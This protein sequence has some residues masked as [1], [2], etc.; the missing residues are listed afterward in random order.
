MWSFRI[1]IDLQE[2]R[3]RIVGRESIYFLLYYFRGIIPFDY[4][5]WMTALSQH[6][7]WCVPSSPPSPCRSLCWLY[8]ENG[9]DIRIM[10]CVEGPKKCRCWKAKI[11]DLVLGPQPPLVVWILCFITPMDRAHVQLSK[12]VL[13]FKNGQ[14]IKVLKLFE[15]YAVK[16]GKS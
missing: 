8:G 15:V 13:I 12:S 2:A 3:K 1:E 10:M 5:Y 9:V 11:D 16:T 4:E 6:L 7:L 14:K